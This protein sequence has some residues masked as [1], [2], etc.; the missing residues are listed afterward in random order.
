M[1]VK[2]FTFVKRWLKALYLWLAEKSYVWQSLAVI[3]LAF[4]APAFWFGF[5]ETA[6]RQAGLVL[7][8]CGI[9]TVAWGI[10]KTRSL[11]GYPTMPSAARNWIFR[12]PRFRHR[13]ATGSAVLKLPVP[14]MRMQGY[15][16]ETPGPNAS[17]QE[18]IEALER[19]LE[20]TNRRLDQLH[21][22]TSKEFRKIESAL[23]QEAHQRVS[24]DQVLR[25]KLEATAT[26]GLH[27]T[28]MGALWLFFGVTMSTIPQELAYL[29]R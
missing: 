12:F 27:I 26:G 21:D 3:A 13:S 18:R 22:E 7:Q 19:N 8:L 11:F 6:I 23:K 16:T 25:Q 5:S 15:K 14:L 9:L 1:L 10:K 4:V 24:E 28:A 17:F 29:L 2:Q 20:G